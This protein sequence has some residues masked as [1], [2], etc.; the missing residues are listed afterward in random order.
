MSEYSMIIE[1]YCPTLGKNMPVQVTYD[2]K[3]S[4]IE[5]C[6]GG[7]QCGKQSCEHQERKIVSNRE[8]FI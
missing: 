5:S 1:R 8:E 7:H 2:E 6:L 3:G 4:R